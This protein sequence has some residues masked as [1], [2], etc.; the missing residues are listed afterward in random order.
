MLLKTSAVIGAAMAASLALKPASPPVV[1]LTARDFQFDSIPDIPAGVVE[2]RLHNAGPNIHH[3]AVFKLR[4]GKNVG[5][6]VAALK[7]PGPP[8]RW[9]M[10]VPSP[11]A[12]APG[13]ESNAITTL[14][15]GRYAVFCFV[16]MP[17]GVPHFMKGMARQFNV[18]ASRN[19]AV[20]PKPA[21][22]LVLADYNFKFNKTL[23]AGT[24][25]IHA[26]N[27]AK[28]GHEVEFF[29]LAPG[30][31]ITDMVSWIE[32]PMTTPPPGKPM[33]GIVLMMPGATGE[34]RITLTPGEW[35]AI[36]FIPDAKDGKRHYM[37][38][39]TAQYTVK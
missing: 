4:A 1:T 29:Q 33:A 17:G 39:M 14:S 19:I 16:D 7:N 21:I 8:P 27:V 32:G 13:D 2:L 25:V 15:P 12:P 38:G 23:T 9:A 37:H 5:D 30:K 22:H 31:T 34:F 35:G 26:V 6:L 36:C 28:Q 10:P 3:A 20:A 24:H 18:V 11:N